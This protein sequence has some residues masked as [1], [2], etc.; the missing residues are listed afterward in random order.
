MKA[1]G[2]DFARILVKSTG[3][4]AVSETALIQNAAKVLRSHALATVVTIFVF[5]VPDAIDL[6]NNRIS[7]KQFAK[8]FSVTAASIIAGTAG[9][10]A[11]KVVG[12]TVFP[13]VGGT[14]GLIVGGGVVAGIAGWGADMLADTITNDD[15]DEL[16]AIFEETY[17]KYCEEYML[18]EQEAGNVAN[19]FGDMLN[20]EMYRDIYKDMYQSKNRKAFANKIL[21][22][23]FE[24]EVKKREM[25]KMPT[26]KEMREQLKINLKGVV[27]I[28]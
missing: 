27:F 5:S 16:Y 19:A 13:G 22:P 14:V 23:L 3:E 7:Q 8:N 12:N 21:I 24:E 26:E 20:D 1:F 28:H 11:G 15:A 25:I 17:V 2:D 10:I 18:N 6:F 9:A 4:T